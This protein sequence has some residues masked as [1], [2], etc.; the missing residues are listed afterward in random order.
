MFGEIIQGIQIIGYPI[1]T[2]HVNCHPFF[3]YN[4][5]VSW[6]A[7]CSFKPTNYTNHTATHVERTVL[8]LIAEPYIETLYAV[9]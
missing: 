8:N 7:S 1:N 9:K 3:L 6:Q 5:A 2:S 4:S